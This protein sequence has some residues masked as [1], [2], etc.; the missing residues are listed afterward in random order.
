MASERPGQRL[1]AARACPVC[2][3]P[4]APFRRR[5]PACGFAKRPAVGGA[6]FAA[7]T[8]LL[9]RYAV[10]GPAVP[11]RIGTGAA[12]WGYD[13]LERRRVWLT[14]YA[15]PPTARGAYLARSM[16]LE[17]L[18][19]CAAVA[20]PSALVAA[21]ELLAAVIPAPVD[22]LAAAREPMGEAPLQALLQR[23]TDALLVLH[24]L[25]GQMGGS[26]AVH[27]APALDMLWRMPGGEVRL[28]VPPVP[29]Q[30]CPADD[31]RGFGSALTVL[32]GGGAAL[33]PALLA[34]LE[35]MCAGGYASV[36]EI[37][38]ELNCL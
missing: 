31:I 12:Y 2:G 27:G 21:G 37:K 23:L 5:C 28:F 25:D 6:P 10:G 20:V 1:P 11:P 19:G 33:S 15:V 16:A 38:H 29:A 26:A 17:S 4:R 8:L 18:A 9:E 22:T 13:R 7:G 35:R 24:S 3:A 36:L 14:A 34:V 32:S 30:G